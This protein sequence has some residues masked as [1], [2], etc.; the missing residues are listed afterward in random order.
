MRLDR[1]GRDVTQM[2]GLWD[3]SD[4]EFDIVKIGG[5]LYRRTRTLKPKVPGE[6]WMPREWI[7]T[8]DS[9]SVIDQVKQQPASPV[10]VD[11]RSS[12]ICDSRLYPNPDCDIHGS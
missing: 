7:D 11:Q 5:N 10:L 6:K 2:P 3:E 8:Y 4:T 1:E 9:I 12:C